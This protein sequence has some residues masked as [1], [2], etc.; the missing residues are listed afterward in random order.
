MC[1]RDFSFSSFTT[2]VFCSSC[3]YSRKVSFYLPAFSGWVNRELFSVAE[4]VGNI[5]LLDNVITDWFELH[6]AH[7]SYNT[8]LHVL[9]RN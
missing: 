8:S 7:F 9:V 5:N 6:A 4:I 2:F 1:Y 3:Y